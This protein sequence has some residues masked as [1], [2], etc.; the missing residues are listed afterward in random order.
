MNFKQHYRKMFDTL[1]YPLR[2]S[3][4]LA[5]STID[6]AAERL[7]VRVPKA[8]RDFYLVA[9]REKR[10]NHCHNRIL[11]PK[12]WRVSKNKLIFMEENQWVVWWAVS[13]G[14]PKN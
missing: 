8:L 13:T 6:R 2:S 9:G 4:A 7:N 14:N 5:A 10:F 12:N 11:G 1:G 3:H